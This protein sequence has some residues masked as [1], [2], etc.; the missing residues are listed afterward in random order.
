MANIALTEHMRETLEQRNGE[1]FL[2]IM[3]HVAKEIGEEPKFVYN[4]T[5]LSIVNNGHTI[6]VNYSG[7][8]F[9]KMGSKTF[10]LL[11]FHFH[12]PSENT[13]DGKPYKMEAHL[14][15]KDANGQLAV[16]GV[17]IKEGKENHFIKTLWNNLP[18]E[19][20]KEN[21]VNSVSINANDLLPSDGSY[22]HLSGSLTTPPCSENVNWNVLR[23]P[24][25]V[26]AEQVKKF[27]SLIG[28]NARPTQPL[29][30]RAIIKL[31]TGSTEILK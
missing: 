27:V 2:K 14:V 23:T 29:N 7:D 30:R 17:F 5:P 28:H 4:A 26:S 15:H 16:V 9:I 19:I 13:V 10:N 24:I 8:S 6:Q 22:Y 11:Q 25:E 1:N 12:S 18:S 20:N 31:N 21:F 3:A